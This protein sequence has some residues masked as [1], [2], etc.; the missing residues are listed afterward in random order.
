MLEV[1]LSP[2]LIARHLPNMSLT[3]QYGKGKLTCSLIIKDI[4]LEMLYRDLGA[5]QI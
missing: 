4:S 5:C 2:L 1:D 3:Y